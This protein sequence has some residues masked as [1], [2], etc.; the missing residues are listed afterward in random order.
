MKTP[1]CPVLALVVGAASYLGAVIQMGPSNEVSLS[2]EVNVKN[3][4]WWPT[5][6]ESAL[7]EFV[8]T[9]ECAKC[10]DSKATTYSM[11]AMAHAAALAPDSQGLRQHDRLSFQL[12]PFHY[13]ILTTSTASL[14]SLSDGSSTLSQTLTWAFGEGQLGQTYVYEEQ[15]SFYE[16]HL[17]HSVI[18]NCAL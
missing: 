11:A 7:E 14:L 8:G 4:G 9:Q 18:S 15:D 10:H 3:S 17:K 1:P 6:G 12:G 16:G 5:R 13:Q 2:T